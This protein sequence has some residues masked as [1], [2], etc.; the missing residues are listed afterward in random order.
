MSVPY[1]KI[2]R[3]DNPIKP[4]MDYY[5]KNLKE[6][7][8]LWWLEGSKDEELVLPPTIRL[9]N[10]L[11]PLEQRK[12]IVKALVL[13]PE[14]LGKTQ[15]K[16][17]RFSIW[18]V[19]EHGIVHPNARDSFTAGGQCE[20]KV[21]MRKFMVPKILEKLST[22]VPEVL[23][24]VKMLPEQEA[25]YYWGADFTGY[26]TLTSQW[27]NAVANEAEGTVSEDGFNFKDFI[28]ELTKA[29]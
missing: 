16:F 24:I 28:R 11:D 9:W 23:D 29:K 22:L 21:G 2:R 4:F 1:E 18:L 8:E 6:G 20:I 19:R 14:I 27:I 13:F 7:E 25:K 26:G 12:I 17:N 3:A 5:R 15:K 10:N